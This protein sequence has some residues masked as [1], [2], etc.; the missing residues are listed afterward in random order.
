MLTT[1]IP[2]LSLPEAPAI[3]SQVDV[4]VDG[5]T[6]S[7]TYHGNSEEKGTEKVSW[8]GDVDPI[9]SPPANT[10]LK[11]TVEYTHEAMSH[12]AV[13]QSNK[14]PKYLATYTLTPSCTDLPSMHN[15]SPSQYSPLAPSPSTYTPDSSPISRH[16]NIF[17]TTNRPSIINKTASPSSSTSEMIADITDAETREY[18]IL[19]D[20]QPL[21][22]HF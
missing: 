15:S 19:L 4:L 8:H 21:R 22:K 2:S 18:E 12:T 6:I 17:S 10:G 20:Q 3:T 14:G 1:Q 5:K 13:L 16:N 11:I 7:V 9:E